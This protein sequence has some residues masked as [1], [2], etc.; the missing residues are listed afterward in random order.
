MKIEE[1]G[2]ILA[3]HFV[4]AEPQW[5][6]HLEHGGVTLSGFEVRRTYS[7]EINDTLPGAEVWF[8]P[9]KR[10]AEDSQFDRIKREH[11]SKYA[12]VLQ[13]NGFEVRVLQHALL[14]EES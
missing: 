8:R 10:M 6:R 14:V 3:A 5:N 13:E 2:E 4:K 9:S 1:V 11:L 12:Q 7:T